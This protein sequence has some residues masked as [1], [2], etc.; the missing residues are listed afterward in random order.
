LFTAVVSSSDVSDLSDVFSAD[1]VA[2]ATFIGLDL[3]WGYRN[4]TGGAVIQRGR[5]V[6]ATGCLTTDESI[7][8]FIAENLAPGRPAVVAVDAPLRVPNETGRR[9]CDH[10]VSAVWRRDEAGAYPANRRL[11]ARDG[12]VRGETLVIHL[13]D[14]F[15]FV[16]TAPIPHRGPGRYV[17]EVF[18]HPAHVTLFGLART[19]KY[20]RKPGRTEIQ[21]LAEF[22]RYQALLAGLAHADP[23]LAGL[24]PFT[25]LDA[26]ALPRAAVRRLEEIL[27]AITCA[28]VGW[29]GWWHGSERQIVYGS[30]GEGHILVPVKYV[31]AT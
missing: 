6:A 20:K 21:R 19:L 17:C 23:P 13:R 14:C 2:D 31:I 24:E 25:Q 16:E 11:L 18:P 28:Y 8:S 5:L 12:A 4:R 22:A 15:G 30:V 29:Y 9:R 1:Q 7:L 10:E 27:D 3:A 26:A